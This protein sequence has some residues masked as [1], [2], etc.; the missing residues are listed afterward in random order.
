MST[1]SGHG[2]RGV[3][4]GRGSGLLSAY[5]LRIALG[6]GLFRA[7]PGRRQVIGVRR[8]RIRFVGVA[9]DRLLGRPAS[10]RRAIARLGR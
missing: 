1:A 2:N 8:G 7:G 9:T 3:R 4:P 10:L 5:P 6:K